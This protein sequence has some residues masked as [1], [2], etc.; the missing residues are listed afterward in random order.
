MSNS[1]QSIPKVFLSLIYLKVHCG[2]CVSSQGQ[3]ARIDNEGVAELSIRVTH[4]SAMTAAKEK[5]S[6]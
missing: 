4:E 2:H 5:S 1:C 3:R 6:L